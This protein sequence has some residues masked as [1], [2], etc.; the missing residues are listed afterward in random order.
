MRILTVTTALHI[1]SNISNTYLCNESI[2]GMRTLHEL[3]QIR[4][5]PI[6][7]KWEQK[8]WIRTIIFSP[9]PEEQLFL[10]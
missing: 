7:F 5:A 1:K 8:G 10:F 3:K 9:N 2:E 4:D 6:D